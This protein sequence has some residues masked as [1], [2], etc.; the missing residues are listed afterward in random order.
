MHR[1]RCIIAENNPQ[2]HDPDW[3]EIGCL[4]RNGVEGMMVYLSP[5][6]A[7]LDAQARNRDGRHY[8]VYPFEGIDPRPFVTSHNH[9]FTLYLAYG[10]AACGPHLLVSERGEVQAL[11]FGAHFQITPDIADHF[12]LLFTDQLIADIDA[13]HRAAGLFDYGRM[14]NELAECTT[15]DLDQQAEQAM[16]RIGQVLCGDNEKVTHC[17]LYDTVDQRWRFA[18]FADLGK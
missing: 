2:P 12:H 1:Y 5:L 15:Q 17:A 10:F 7:M 11:I 9:W 18:S 3:A 13:V 14:V 16:N 4:S 8:R 6:D